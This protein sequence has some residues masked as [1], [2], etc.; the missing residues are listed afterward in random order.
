[1]TFHRHKFL[2]IGSFA[3]F[4][5][6]A[7]AQGRQSGLSV[8]PQIVRTAEAGKKPV[9]VP[10][11]EIIVRLQDRTDS[12]AFARAYG[13][14]PRYTLKSD[15]QTWIFAAPSVVE[16]DAI[17][18]RLV[19]DRRVR[20]AF[21]NSRS[22]RQ[23]TDFVPNDPYFAPFGAG[24]NQI[25]QWYIHNTQ[26][27]S[28]DSEA[29]GAWGRNLTGSGIIVALIDDGMQTDHPDL[30][31]NYDA[32]DSMDM[33][34][35]SPDPSPVY[36][37]DN[38]GTA[39]AGLIAAR[40][41]NGV[42]ITGNAPFARLA[43]LREDFSLGTDA[44]FAD[45][46]L[47]HS[48]GANTQIKVKS[49]SYGYS[50][51]Y[52]DDTV[53]T[54]AIT[55][56]A[57]VGTIHCYAAGNERGSAGQDTNTK[58]ALTNPAAFVIA[59]INSY[60]QFS[61]YSDFGANVTAVM[62]SSGGPLDILTT[63]RTGAD[64]YNYSAT[65]GNIP[66]V[67]Y[68]ASF[69]GTSAATPQAAGVLVLVKQ[70][71]PALDS[72]FAKHLIARTS[73]LLDPNDS[74]VASDGGWKTNAAGFKFNQNYGFG[75]LNADLLT[76]RAVQFTGTTPLATANIGPVTVNATIPDNSMAGIS[77]TFTLNATA[78]LEE[79][80]I[81]LNIAHPLRGQ[82]EAYLTSPGGT[83]SRLFLQAPSDTDPDIHWTYSSNAFW[84]ENPQGVWTLNVRDVAAGYTG[85]W[86][87]FS[88]QAR[89]GT[90]LAKVA[91]NVTLQGSVNA[92]QSVTFTFR[93]ADGT[94][95]FTRTQTL[96]AANGSATGN[97]LLPNIPAGLYQVAIRGTNFL[98]RVVT[99]DTRN[100]GVSGVNVTLSGG[101][102]NGDNVVDIADFGI[103]INAYN[104]DS[105]LGGSGYDPRADFNDDGVVDIGDFGVLVNNYGLA[106]DS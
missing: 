58:Q 19:Q 20:K 89:M 34:T 90:L 26:R 75:L 18:L 96:L 106:G 40:G 86:S 8:A 77:Q 27:L 37:D 56:A 104:S 85:T 39:C 44:Q 66:D 72:R 10:T 17:R 79:V 83:K 13:L 51:P 55:E 29:L 43:C 57:A 52:Y 48:S 102:A 7:Q 103:L 78:P 1:M 45:A 61:Y 38:H 71:Q 62:P 53:E 32:A 49:S 25:G 4:A 80:L 88:V 50:D 41:G 74:S 54:D 92:N 84:G 60:G 46:T 94:P 99:I 91:G 69:G 2:A 33:Y 65:S 68:T 28:L 21:A 100:G 30:A 5:V 87:D 64:G 67:N 59:A 76:Q 82:T 16:A 81:T 70:A 11:E 23:R 101:D 95:A 42:G 93:P 63:D 105:T 31:P 12:A 73:S 6:S 98:Q 36:G 47:Y 9:R 24:T 15:P 22:L 14:T 97:F 35:G 3:C